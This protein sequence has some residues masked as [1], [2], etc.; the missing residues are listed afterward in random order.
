[1]SKK[2]FLFWC[3]IMAEGKIVKIGEKYLLIPEQTK[4]AKVFLCT[5]NCT[6]TMAGKLP[7]KPESWTGKWPAC[8]QREPIKKFP[9]RPVTANRRQPCI[10]RWACEQRESTQNIS[11][12]S[13]TV[14][15]RGCFSQNAE[16]DQIS[17]V[18]FS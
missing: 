10:H 3:S 1:M 13:C 17:K 12:T 8:E 7:E 6:E 11:K 18:P 16:N 14:N 5:A 2:S 9:T 15:K 4:R